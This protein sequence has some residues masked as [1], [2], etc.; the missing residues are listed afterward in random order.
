MAI[1]TQHAQCVG[2]PNRY[3]DL[4]AAGLVHPPVYRYDAYDVQTIRQPCTRKTSTRLIT[5]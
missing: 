1:I 2:V 4:A 5:V 3:N